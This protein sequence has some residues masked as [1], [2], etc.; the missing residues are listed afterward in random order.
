MFIRLFLFL[1]PFLLLD[2]LFL[3][4]LLDQLKLLLCVDVLLDEVAV[5]KN[6][7]ARDVI[8]KVVLIVFP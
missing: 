3:L 5:E 8:H 6:D 4:M 1:L 2:L 7:H